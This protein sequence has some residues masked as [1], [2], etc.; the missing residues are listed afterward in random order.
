M[1]DSMSL[2]HSYIIHWGSPRQLLPC[3]PAS[4]T[5]L[6]SQLTLHMKEEL[7]TIKVTDRNRWAAALPVITRMSLATSVAATGVTQGMGVIRVGVIGS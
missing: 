2:T 4:P 5:L 6:L 7:Y 1:I 3:G